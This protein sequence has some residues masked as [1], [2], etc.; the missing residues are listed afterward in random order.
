MMRS[1][2]AT[3]RRLSMSCMPFSLA[4]NRALSRAACKSNE[5]LRTIAWPPGRSCKWTVGLAARKGP[6]PCAPFQLPALV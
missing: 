6:L 4:Y 5:T 2:P 1:L 3:G